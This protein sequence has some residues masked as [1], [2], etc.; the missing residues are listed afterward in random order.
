MT[1]ALPLFLVLVVGLAL[2]LLTL[3]F[4]DP[5]PAQGGRRVPAHDHRLAGGLLDLPEGTWPMSCAVTSTGPIVRF[6]PILMVAIL[7]GLAMDYEVFLVSRMR[8][9]YVH[10]GKAREAIV[11][12][13]R[14]SARVVTA[15]ALIMIAV[16]S[17]SSSATTWSSSR[18]AWRKLAFG[19]LVDAFLVRMTLV[20]AV[21]ATL[22]RRAW[23]L[24]RWLDRRMPNLDIEGENLPRA[25]AAAAGQ[26][27]TRVSARARRWPSDRHR[28]GGFAGLYA[29]RP[30]AHLLKHSGRSRWSASR[31]SCSTRRCRPR[32]RAAP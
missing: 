16:F 6:L 23:W 20:P 26:P 21:L 4:V 29:A 25:R 1:A 5:G 3:V 12:G 19:V 2:L 8:E 28:G 27:A 10:K 31:T 13:F 32:L 15:A 30:A 24:P 9:S 7:F 14:A 17:A 18:S 22:D 11:E